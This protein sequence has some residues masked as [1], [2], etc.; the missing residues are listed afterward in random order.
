MDIE[1]FLPHRGPM[2][3]LTDIINIDRQTATSRSKVIKEWPL[4][5]PLGVNPLIL[6]EL[7]AQTAGIYN[8]YE[9]VKKEGADSDIRGWIVGVKKAL[10]NV[11]FIPFG[12]FVETTAH[13]QFE[14]EQLREVCGVAKVENEVVGEVTLQLMREQ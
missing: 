1:A 14:Y 7:V 4:T 12:A 2:L 9:V 11:A 10:F 3:L 8:S 6:I 5:S 13:N